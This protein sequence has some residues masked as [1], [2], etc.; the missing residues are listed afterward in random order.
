M[1]AAHVDD[2]DTYISRSKYE[3]DVPQET[4]LTCGT[5]MQGCADRVSFEMLLVFVTAYRNGSISR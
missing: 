3:L 1:R 5:T 4:L 2:I